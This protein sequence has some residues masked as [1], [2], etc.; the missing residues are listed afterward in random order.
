M[1]K[2]IIVP[3]HVIVGP[4]PVAAFSELSLLLVAIFVWAQGDDL[5]RPFRSSSGL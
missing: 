1:A 5:H 2:P 3:V 4:D